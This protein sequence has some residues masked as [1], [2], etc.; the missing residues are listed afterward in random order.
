MK[1]NEYFDE[2]IFKK[3]DNKYYT[4]RKSNNALNEP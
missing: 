2:E 3:V 1:Q 4:P